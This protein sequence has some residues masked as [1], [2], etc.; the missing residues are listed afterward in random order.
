MLL[1]GTRDVIVITTVS[2]ASAGGKLLISSELR[3]DRKAKSAP[4]RQSH[5]EA[6]VWRAE[7]AAVTTGS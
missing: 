4:E 6:T 3:T 5:E 1:S 7:R 2:T